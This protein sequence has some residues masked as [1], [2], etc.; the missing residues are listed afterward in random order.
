[1]HDIRFIR[2]NPDAFDRALTRR[3]SASEEKKAYSSQHLISID[4]RRRAIIRP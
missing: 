1:M 4:E 3:E 2:E